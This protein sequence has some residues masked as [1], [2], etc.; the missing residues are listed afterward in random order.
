MKNP[1][2]CIHSPWAGVSYISLRSQVPVEVC[3]IVVQGLGFFICEIKRQ[4]KS[5]VNCVLSIALD[6]PTQLHAV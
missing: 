4:R 2:P 6:Q 5:N 3:H 1:K